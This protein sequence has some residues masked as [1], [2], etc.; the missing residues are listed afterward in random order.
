MINLHSLW[1]YETKIRDELGLKV[2]L[3][4]ADWPSIGQRLSARRGRRSEIRFNGVVVPMAKVR[5]EI[6]RNSRRQAVVEAENLPLPQDVSIVTP[7]Q[8]PRS[9]LGPCSMNELALPITNY[10]TL[11][12]SKV[13]ALVLSQQTVSDASRV[14]RTRQHGRQIDLRPQYHLM[15]D[16]KQRFSASSST[17][18][19]SMLIGKYLFDNRFVENFGALLVSLPSFQLQSIFQKYCNFQS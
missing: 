5:K 13:N 16:L 8:S 9:V 15:M 1:K 19:S 14:T 17:S 4:S 10:H 12:N 2:K 11:N 7:P 3:K 6:A 18:R